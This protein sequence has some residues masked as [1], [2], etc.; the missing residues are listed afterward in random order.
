MRQEAKPTVRT[1]QQITRITTRELAQAKEAVGLLLEE[2]KLSAYLFEVEPRNGPWNV[3]IDCAA[4]GCWQSL[5]LSVD[6]A[7]L[8]DVVNNASARNNLLGRWRQEL[9]ACINP[10]DASG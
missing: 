2:L 8:I 6:V 4:S 1:D 7:E 3:Q 9:G 5:T 10:T